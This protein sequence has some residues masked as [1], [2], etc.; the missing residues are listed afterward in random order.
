LRPLD[1][2][3]INV[4]YLL[5]AGGSKAKHSLKMILKKTAPTVLQ[6]EE[7]TAGIEWFACFAHLKFLG[8]HTI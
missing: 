3:V 5:I 4:N 7:L 1:S 8:L 6:R 2:L